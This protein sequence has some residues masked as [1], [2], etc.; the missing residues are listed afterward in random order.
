MS[1]DGIG[2]EVSTTSMT[3]ESTTRYLNITPQRTVASVEPRLSLDVRSD[4]NRK[5]ARSAA[6]RVIPDLIEAL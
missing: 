3:P 6:R 1:A 5:N 2:H 4:S